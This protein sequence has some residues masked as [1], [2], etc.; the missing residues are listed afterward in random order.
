MFRIGDRGVD[1]RIE[2]V[3]GQ[4]NIFLRRDVWKKFLGAF[5]DLDLDLDF[6]FEE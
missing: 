4:G 5:L 1:G 3:L 2:R 6:T